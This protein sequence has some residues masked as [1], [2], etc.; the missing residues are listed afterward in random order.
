VVRSCGGQGFVSARSDDYLVVARSKVNGRGPQD[1][2]L[3]V[4]HEDAGHLD[5]LSGSPGSPGV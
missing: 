4:H 3:D 2:W 5:P 1:L